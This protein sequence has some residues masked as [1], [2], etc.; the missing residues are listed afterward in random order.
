[1]K[2]NKAQILAEIRKLKT[3]PANYT[4]TVVR[5]D[6]YT[7]VAQRMVEKLPHTPVFE[8]MSFKEIRSYCKQPV[9]TYFYNSRA[10]PIKAFGQD[11]EELHAFYTTLE[12]LFP[13]AINVM[14]AIND[15]WDNT[16]MFHTHT[17]PDG[18]VSHVKV[19]T[20]VEGILDNEGLNLPYL[21]YKNQPSDIGTPLVANFTHAFDAFGVRHVADNADF[22]FS[23]VHDE[24]KAHPNNMGRVRE[25]FIDSIRITASQ[26]YLEEFCEQDFGIDNRAFLAGLKTSKYAIC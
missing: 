21:Y 20:A 8:G 12:E 5:A 24:Y 6:P 15:R 9:M 25:L 17:L 10:E 19:T 23:H 1:M 2:R 18:H 13:G 7:L 11:T 22:D 26:P 14:E 3:N 16:A 4:E